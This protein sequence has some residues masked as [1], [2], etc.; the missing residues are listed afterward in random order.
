MGPGLQFPTD[1]PKAPVGSDQ[2]SALQAGRG[3]RAYPVLRGASSICLTSFLSS[4]DAFILFLAEPL[5]ELEGFLPL[6]Q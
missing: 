4:P 1:D 5:Q 6:A 3:S 2:P